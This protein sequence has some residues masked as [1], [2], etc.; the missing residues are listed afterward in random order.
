MDDL[1]VSCKKYMLFVGETPT[2]Q[3]HSN[4]VVPTNSKISKDGEVRGSSQTSKSKGAN[5]SPLTTDKLFW[6]FFIILNGEHEYEIDNSFKREK[7]IKIESIE[8]LRKIKSELKALKL[9]LNAI[10]NELLNEKK[11][12]IK[13][14]VALCL[15]YKKNVMYVWNRKYF[16]IINNADEP[17]NI[18]I[19][20]NGEDKISDDIS[21]TKINYYKDNYWLIENIEK[22]L[23]AMTGYT[24]D[25]LFII[26]QKLD[27]KEITIKKTK[28]EMYEK[29]LE[30][31]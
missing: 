12:S 15:L 4:D 18:I 17:I 5:R 30:K 10:E 26:T 6:C 13:S 8:K 28:K 1:I 7:E 14:L 27:I 24:K 21:V 22:P 2:P 19:N 23:K 31:L 25:E 3:L 20:E 9:R 11:I 29:I 16:E